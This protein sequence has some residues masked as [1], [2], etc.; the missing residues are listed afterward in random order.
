[1]K[2]RVLVWPLLLVAACSNN[3]TTKA[4]AGAGDAAVADSAATADRGSS[5]GDGPVTSK[6]GGGTKDLAAA[7]DSAP[8]TGP[9]DPNKPLEL[10]AGKAFSSTLKAAS[11]GVETVHF[12]K[13]TTAGSGRYTVSLEAEQDVQ[14]QWCDKSVITG[15]MCVAQTNYTTCCYPTAG[16]TTCSFTME[17]SAG[18]GFPAG[19]TIYPSVFH[20][21]PKD[22]PYTLTI[23]GPL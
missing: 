1:M 19:T 23:T 6:D 4:D 13:F 22:I 3:G 14:A 17:K 18:T 12:F 20:F 16:K 11:G 7:K 5:T 8:A 15:C 2:R 10:T 21:K 9:T